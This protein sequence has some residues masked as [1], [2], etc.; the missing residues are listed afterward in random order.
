MG[1]ALLT[2]FGTVVGLVGAVIVLVYVVIPAIEHV[3]TFVGRL[4]RFGFHELRDLL[5]IPIA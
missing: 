4:F 1:T 5:L 2:C 3:F